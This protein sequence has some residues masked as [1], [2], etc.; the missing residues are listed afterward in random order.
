MIRGPSQATAKVPSRLLLEA[1]E[2]QLSGLGM[3]PRLVPESPGAS[4]VFSGSTDVNGR[5]AGDCFRSD[6]GLYG[7]D[8]PVHF[9]DVKISAQFFTSGPSGVGMAMA[10]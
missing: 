3:V 9:T 2:D 7:P 8:D 1:R 10:P 4:R 6:V 5:T